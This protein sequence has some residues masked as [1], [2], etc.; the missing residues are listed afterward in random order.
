[1][2]CPSPF[3]DGRLF[4]TE[5][6]ICYR[7]V[8]RHLVE[9][10]LSSATSADQA[11]ALLARIFDNKPVEG[12]YAIALNSCGDLLGIIRHSEGTV[13]RSSVYPRELVSF[14]LVETNATGLILA[15]NHPGGRGEPS[16]EDLALTS[17]LKEIVTPLG[18][19][20]LDHFLY[21]CGRP[22][23]APEWIS[24]RERGHL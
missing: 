10:D 19:R 21:S 13:D 7:K 6:A 9:L 17:R 14:L 15:H 23:M 8:R 2:S 16:P 24:L 18:V 20:L 12:L 1:M 4:I 22:G 11:K 3:K 5:K